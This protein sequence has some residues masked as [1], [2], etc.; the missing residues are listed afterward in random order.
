[1]QH[2]TRR[3]FPLG[4]TARIGAKSLC[5]N[6]YPQAREALCKYDLISEE[7]K[8]VRLG[9][10]FSDHRARGSGLWVW[11]YRRG[12]GGHCES[13]VRYISCAVYYLVAFRVAGLWSA[14]WLNVV[15]L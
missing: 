8:H 14:L 1:M 5:A 7:V 2:P 12:I 11:R 15:W 4:Q 10:S 6:T 3:C 13:P 9:C